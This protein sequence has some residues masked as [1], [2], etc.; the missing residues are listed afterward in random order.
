MNIHTKNLKRTLVISA[1][2]TIL[3]YLAQGI[4]DYEGVWFVVSM[5]SNPVAGL[6]HANLD[7]STGYSSA[8]FQPY[9]IQGFITYFLFTL[10]FWY[11]LL[12]LL[13]KIKEWRE[14]QK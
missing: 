7:R 9:K 11:I 8:F 3:P 4:K 12:A 14:V 5:I 13:S 6:L 2:V 1:V 10:G